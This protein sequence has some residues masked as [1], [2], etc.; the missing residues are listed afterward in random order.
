MSYNSVFYGALS[1]LWIIFNQILILNI[2]LGSY[3]NWLSFMEL[4]G[5]L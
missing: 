3:R 2:K 1:K 4:G 5:K